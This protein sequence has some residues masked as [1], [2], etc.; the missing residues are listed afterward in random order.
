[1]DCR[2]CWDDKRLHERKIV[3]GFELHGMVAQYSAARTTT[4]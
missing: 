2:L 1:V 3:I 4:M